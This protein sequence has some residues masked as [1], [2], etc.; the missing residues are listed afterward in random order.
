MNIKGT[1]L[2]SSEKSEEISLHL[3]EPNDLFQNE[4]L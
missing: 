1:K 2:N 4:N 3:Y